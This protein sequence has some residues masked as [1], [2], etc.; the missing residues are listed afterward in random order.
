MPART[1]IGV[2]DLPYGGVV[3]VECI[4]ETDLAAESAESAT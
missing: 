4:A 2:Q 3:E 1:C